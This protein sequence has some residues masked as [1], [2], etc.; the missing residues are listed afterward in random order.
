LDAERGE[1]LS[2]RFLFDRD[3]FEIRVLGD[4]AVEL[5]RYGSEFRE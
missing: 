5:D 2:R 3:L 1:P 4:V